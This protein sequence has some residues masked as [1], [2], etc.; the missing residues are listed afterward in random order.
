MLKEYI[1]TSLNKTSINDVPKLFTNCTYLTKKISE[2]IVEHYLDDIS[3]KNNM[4]EDFNSSISSALS[5]V[6]SNSDFAEKIEPKIL[7]I[8]CPL[9]DRMNG[10]F[11]SK[12]NDMKT[13]L[14]SSNNN[15]DNF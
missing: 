2:S 15:E 4:G 11:D 5:E 3:N 8:I 6:I 1:K 10:I 9:V 12:L 13:K 7:G 14:M